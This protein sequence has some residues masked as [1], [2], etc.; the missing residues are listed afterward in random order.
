MRYVNAGHNYPILR[1]TSGQIERLSTG[2]PPLGLP[3]FTPKEVPYQS[4]R[5]QLQPGDL[6]FIFTDGVVEAV[7]QAEE[8]YGE[9]RLLPCLQTV[10]AENSAA[11]VLRRVMFDVNSFV[12]QV[13][14]HDDITCLVLR[15]TA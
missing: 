15:V 14:Q 4:G 10:P 8:E 11:D 2:G 13:R 12:G 1:R 6:L 5:I 3:L 7:N 9:R